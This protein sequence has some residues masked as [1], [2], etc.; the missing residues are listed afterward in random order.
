MIIFDWKERKLR[1]NEEPPIRNGCERDR[2]DASFKPAG[3]THHD[4]SGIESQKLKNLGPNQAKRPA[5][6]GSQRD[7]QNRKH[8]FVI[9]QPQ[10][11]YHDLRLDSL[12][13]IVLLEIIA[14][15]N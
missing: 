12:Q 5:E 10:I 4:D 1:G 7:A 9:V 14:L 2:Y 11:I 8:H 3:K 15:H 6:R 13:A